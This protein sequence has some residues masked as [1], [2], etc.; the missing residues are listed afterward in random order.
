MPKIVVIEDDP[1]IF[2]LLRYNLTSE[3]FS[4]AGAQTGA[5]ALE[6]CRLEQPGLVV[7]DILLPDA[8]GLDICRA[9]RAD[10]ELGDVPVV[11][12]TA[13]TSESDRVV[14]LELGAND[15]IVKPFFIREFLARV[16][17]QFRSRIQRTRRVLGGPLS[18]HPAT[19]RA[20]LNGAHLSLTATEFRL[21][22]FLMSSPG[23]VFTR[24]QLLEAVWG[25]CRHTSGRVVDVYI[26][27]LRQKIEAT[28]ATPTLI[29]SVRGFGYTFDDRSTHPGLLTS[30]D[31]MFTANS[32]KAG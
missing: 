6:L 32:H 23:Q 18:L 29:H 24:E 3:G 14:G 17:V 31:A 11:F 26:L 2:E 10:A 20:T 8:S 28:P 30:R 15:Y 5:N 1:D 22:E 19:C 4:F 16:K 12:L 9:L 27:R 7:L 13:C 25:G 21:L